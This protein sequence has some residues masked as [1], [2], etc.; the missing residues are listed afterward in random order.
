MGNSVA[1]A[2]RTKRHLRACLITGLIASGIG[3]G[4]VRIIGGTDSIGITIGVC[5]GL[6]L[7]AFELFYVQGRY[8]AWLRGLP[9][10]LFILITTGCWAI[11]LS[12]LLW[13][14]PH[15]M[16]G[17]TY[18][19]GYTSS[20]FQQDLLFALAVGLLFNIGLRLRGLVGGR[21]LFNFLIGRYNRPLREE[22]VFMFLDLVGSTP[23]A[24]KM[25]DLAVQSL[26]GRFFFDIARPIAEHHGETHRYIGD[27]VVVTWPLEEAL[28]DAACVRCVFD[29]QALMK[30]KA[31][32][33]EAEFGVVPEFRIGIHG[34]SVVAGEVGDDKR[35]IVY[36]GDT[37]NT[38]ARLQSLCKDFA[39]NV[40]ISRS[41]LDRMQLPRDVQV[42]ELG[43]VEVRGKTERLDVCTMFRR[44]A[45]Q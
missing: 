11:I 13:G 29:I 42:E 25:G 30:D 9:L 36:F 22:R 45:S 39:C 37:I 7:S 16:Q 20:T 32:A 10:P 18:G 8:G 12:V 6:C 5:I 34:G 21:V 15:L 38:A 3:L 27:E 23:L 33:Y 31:R 40:L 19:T 14:V 28:R 44:S 4:Y 1:I 26:I 43:S 41:L 17:Y 24:E 2:Q 35:E